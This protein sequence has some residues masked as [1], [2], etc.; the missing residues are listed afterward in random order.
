MSDGWV[1]RLEKGM[2][3]RWVLGYQFDVNS[4]AASA[5][6]QDKVA[7]H[8]ALRQ[9]GVPSVE[10]TLIRA[11][12]SQAF[13]VG[14]LAGIFPGPFVLKPLG[15]TGGRGVQKVNSV[16][17]A[18]KVVSRSGEMAWAASP[19]YDISAEYRVIMLDGT[20]LVM[21]EK[22]EPVTEHGLRYFNL[23]KGAVPAAILT[24]DTGAAL[25]VLAR[26]ACGTLSLRLASVDIVRIG[27]VLRVLE[28][29]DGIMMEYYAR[30]SEQYKKNAAL[31]YD[32]IVVTM[33]R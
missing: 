30:H 16:G 22:K 4:A 25:D 20:P 33:F 24:E 21:Y 7:T 1:I 18:E 8:E 26:Q 32:A 29:N 2:V 27:G 11:L 28:I 3:L 14:Q 5:V 13:P 19:L 15:G 31:A 23:G 17:E 12:P 10:H 9:A 6:A